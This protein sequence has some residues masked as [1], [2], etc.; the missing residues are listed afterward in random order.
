MK[1]NGVE[2]F[3][4]IVVYDFVINNSDELVSLAMG[5]NSWRDSEVIL[6]IGNIEK[7]T[8]ENV[9][10]TRVLDVPGVFSN[11]LQWFSVSKTVWEY[12]N[13]YGIKFDVAYSDMEPM[14][15]LHYYAGQGFYKPHCDDGPGTPRIFSALLYL[16]DVAEGGETYF[17]KI[18]I[19]IAPKKGRLVIFPSNYIYTHEA[20]TPISND[21]F[22]LVT[23]F[24]PVL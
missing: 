7:I 8:D 24:K 16:N 10:K 1:N 12:A 21:K 23:W 13:N 20:R 14:Q 4:G 3:P 6:G 11:D 9:R 22:V 15:F 5:K 19:S 17:N 18:N 2:I